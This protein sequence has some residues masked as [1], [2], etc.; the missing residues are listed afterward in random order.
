MAL[1]AEKCVVG[2]RRFRALEEVEHTFDVLLRARVVEHAE[3]DR[4]PAAQPRRRH[5]PETALLE[6]RDKARVEAVEFILVFEAST[7]AG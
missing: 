6:R 5:E 4:I 1:V 2:D 7:K 3:P